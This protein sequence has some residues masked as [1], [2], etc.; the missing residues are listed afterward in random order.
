MARNEQLIR[1]HKILQILEDYRFGRTLSEIRDELVDDLGLTSLHTR[2]VRRDL[3]ALQAAGFDIGVYSIQRGK[4]WKLGSL[5]R[6]SPKITASAT[7]LIS[8]SLGRDLL[9]PLAGTPFW[10]G[11]ESFWK[12]LYE[13]LPASVADHFEKYRRVLYVLGT[14]TKSYAAKQGILKTVNRAILEHRV[15]RIEY[16]APGRKPAERLIEP[17]AIVF[18]Q[19][20]LYIV[21]AAHEV[22]QQDER[23]RHWKLDRFL[24]ATALDQWFKPDPEF[25]LDQ[26]LGHNLGIFSSGTLQAFTIHVSPRAAPWVLEDPWHPDQKVKK[27]EDGSIELTVEATHELEIIPKVLAL[28]S[29]A[30]LIAPASCRKTIAELIGQM[31]AMYAE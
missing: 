14:P 4:V 18:Y 26:Y 2:S 13:Q 22:P 29:E 16:H 10:T 20:S 25:N 9:F 7:E 23:L 6:S 15:V 8:L 17:Y 21:A 30:E 24:R 31:A 1:Q 3:E 27:R 12:K 28:G 11:I 19:S 5:A